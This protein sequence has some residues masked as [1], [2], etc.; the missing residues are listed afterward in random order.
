MNLNHSGA[1]TGSM[2]CSSLMLMMAAPSPQCPKHSALVRHLVIL[3]SRHFA[4]FTGH[5][6]TVAH[7]LWPQLFSA[8]YYSFD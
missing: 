1:A 8:D 6:G 2:S 7:T 3:D 4:L 5:F